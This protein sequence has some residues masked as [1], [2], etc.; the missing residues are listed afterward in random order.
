MFKQNKK[1]KRRQ[2]KKYNKWQK[3]EKINRKLK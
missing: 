2:K 1:K 3:S